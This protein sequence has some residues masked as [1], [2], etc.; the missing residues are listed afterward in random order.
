MLGGNFTLLTQ[1]AHLLFSGH[2]LSFYWRIHRTAV[3]MNWYELCSRLQE[4]Y[5]DQ[6]TDRDIK[7][8]MRRRKQGSNESF[9]DFLDAILTIA[10]SLREPMSDSELTTEIRHNLRSELLHELLHIDTPDLATLRKECHRHEEF[11]RSISSHSRSN[12]RKPVVNAIAHEDESGSDAEEIS[13]SD[14]CA[15]RSL[16]NV[17]CWNCEEQGHRYHDCLQPRR[18]FCYGCGAAET[19]K[20]NCAKCKSDSENMPKDARRN[21]RGDVLR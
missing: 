4:R 10:D 13:A 11:Y 21:P 6:R 9:D 2:A 3:N 18:V 1:F 8:A 5:Q 15:V 14:V 17:K 7:N 19:Y 12:F 16:D 20:P